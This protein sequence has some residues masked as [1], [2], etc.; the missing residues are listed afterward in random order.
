MVRLV[1]MLFFPE[2]ATLKDSLAF[3][4]RTRGD[5]VAVMTP[6]H[7]LTYA[8]LAHNAVVVAHQLRQL[9]VGEGDR[10]AFIAKERG[11]YWE[12][13]FACALM[14]AVIVPINWKLTQEEVAHI[15]KDS[16]AGVILI[17]GD[18]QLFNTTG[19]TEINTLPQAWQAW[20]SAAE[21]KESDTQSLLAGGFEPTP[22]TPV[23]QLYTSGTTGLPK[24]VVL[25]HRS[26]FAVRNALGEAGVEWISFEENDV[27]F[28]GIPGFHV[29]GMWYAM[30]VFN[31]GQTV[32]SVE[33]FN[34]VSAREIFKQ[35]AV[36][37]AILVP[38]M[39]ASIAELRPADPDAFAHMRQVI[40]GGAPIGDSV[41]ANCVRVFGARFAQI[42]GLTETGNTA[43][44]LPP[45]EHYADSPRLKAAGRPYP[46][47]AVRIV[48]EDNAVLPAFEVGEV[49]LYTP[50]R[51]VEYWN[52]PSATS[53]TLVDEADAG[54]I[55]TGD[56][57]FVDDEGFLFIQDRIKD[58]ILVGGE[59]VFPAEVEKVLLREC[60]IA[61]CA[62]IGVPDDRSGEAVL[63]L[64]VPDP[65]TPRPTTRDLLLAVRGKI[66]A[67]KIPSRWEF[68]EQIPRNPSGKILRRALREKYWVGRDRKVN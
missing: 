61:D 64:I 31:A 4:A 67:F 1:T 5:H 32:Y 26:W 35:A 48:D 25:A 15:L 9:G 6:T 2:L 16:G 65:S 44:C 10:V 27:C 23:C 14:G 42:Y 59:N 12:T 22:D 30:Q 46:G 21:L 19:I 45:E 29:G 62:V 60:G 36:T 24:G 58:M 50:A 43:V 40:Y 11:S 8:Q 7:S 13:T 41:L 3:H 51:M 63:A 37:S 68:I 18:H 28:V 52:L 66:A 57:G 55:R 49:L 17:D 39:M 53:E 56:A 33:E 47:F 20:L 38:A 34:P 54:W